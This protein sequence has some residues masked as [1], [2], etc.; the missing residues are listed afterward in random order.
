[1]WWIFSSVKLSVKLI[2]QAPS[3]LVRPF[4]LVHLVVLVRALWTQ[5]PPVTWQCKRV[6][7]KHRGKTR[8]SR[9]L[10]SSSILNSN[11]TCKRRWPIKAR[12]CK[13]NRWA[14]SLGNTALVLVCK[15]YRLGYK[16]LVNWVNWA[17]PCT[18]SKLETLGCSNK[19][20]VNSRLWSRP[21][22]ISR[23]KI[24]VRLS[25]TR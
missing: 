23:F 6:I 3:G 21:R 8:R 18:A 12:G 17:R 16:P 24:T 14:S 2:L 1:M 15:V 25:S 22:S 4:V 11:V 5:K 13:P 20:V 9:T 10:S 19:Q 7:S